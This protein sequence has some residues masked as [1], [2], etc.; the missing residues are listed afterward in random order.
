MLLSDFFHKRKTLIIYVISNYPLMQCYSTYQ[1]GSIRRK[2]Q[3]KKEFLKKAQN[4]K[5][6]NVA[7]SVRFSSSWTVVENARYRPRPL[8]LP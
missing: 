8:A 3:K 7:D 2:I 6:A 4:N 5:I 1:G